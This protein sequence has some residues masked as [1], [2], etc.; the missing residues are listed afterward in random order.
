MFV[1][2]LVVVLEKIDDED[3]NEKARLEFIDGFY[4]ATRNLPEFR[5]L[6]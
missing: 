3:E 4:R 1:L 2:V 5:R 6:S